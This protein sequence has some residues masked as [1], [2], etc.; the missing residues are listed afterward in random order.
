MGV[1]E[2]GPWLHRRVAVGA[3]PT[4]AYEEPL[5]QGRGSISVVPF[6]RVGRVKVGGLSRIELEACGLVGRR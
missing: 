1:T 3:R 4:V 6:S 5:D 2:V